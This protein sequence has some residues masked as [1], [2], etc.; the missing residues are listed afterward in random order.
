MR[1]WLLTALIYGAGAALLFF[2]A[3]PRGY[4]G[5]L[6]SPRPYWDVARY[7]RSAVPR[8]AAGFVIVGAVLTFHALSSRRSANGR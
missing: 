5:G 4:D 3:I 1:I 8:A 7:Q 6:L 2:L